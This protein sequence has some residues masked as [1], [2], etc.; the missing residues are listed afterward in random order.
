MERTDAGVAGNE[1]DR[2]AQET[3]E[4]NKLSAEAEAEEDEKA[5]WLVRFP[6]GYPPYPSTNPEEMA[7]WMT[8]FEEREGPGA[9]KRSPR[10]KH[11]R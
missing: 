10:P 9:I 4:N 7:Y 11:G 3:D 6:S 2:E 8:A 5:S 1:H